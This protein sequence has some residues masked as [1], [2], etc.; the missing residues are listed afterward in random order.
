MSKRNR[1]AKLEYRPFFKKKKNCNKDT[2][3]IEMQ[4][5]AANEIF[6]QNKK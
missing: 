1:G 4:P 6:A 5:K 2:I 3:H